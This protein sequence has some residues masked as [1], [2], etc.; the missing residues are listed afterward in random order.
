M[1][2]SRLIACS[3]LFLLAGL[4]L[5]GCDAGPGAT[6]TPAT[7]LLVPSGTLEPAV[8]LVPIALEV[9][10]V[11]AVGNYA[12]PH[13]L[14]VPSGFE[15]SVFAAGM[16]HPRMMALSPDG[17]LYATVRAEGRIVRLPDKN[18]DGVA[19]EVVT[20]AD[21][22]EAVHG[23]AF[24]DG[25]VYAASE[26]ELLRLEDTDGDGAADKREVLANDLPF[27]GV[28]STRTIRFG[29]PVEDLVHPE[30]VC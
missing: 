10:E 1:N 23:I 27:P 3:L 22:I 25:Q 2:A 29:A 20:F 9:P 17:E 19:D 11:N 26:R 18:N 24:R 5:G 30:Q 15:V 6:P 21:G 16:Q 8:P 28:H 12:Q 14:N 13:T 4:V 7:N